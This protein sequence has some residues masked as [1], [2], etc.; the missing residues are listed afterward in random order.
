MCLVMRHGNLK[1]SNAVQALVS[2]LTTHTALM[3]MGS[4]Q[5]SRIISQPHLVPT[6]SLDHDKLYPLTSD[7][8]D[9]NTEYSDTLTMMTAS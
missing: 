3:A 9:S 2:A 4:L 1:H 8:M 7:I 6:M 5:N